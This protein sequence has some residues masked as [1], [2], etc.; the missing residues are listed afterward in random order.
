MEPL[1]TLARRYNLNVIE[2]AAQAHGT[3]YKGQRAGALGDAAGFSFY[4]SKNLGAFGDAGAVTTNDD[5]L[6]EQVRLLRNYG[7]RVKYENEIAG[8]NSRLDPI[9]AALLRVK[10]AHLD[11]W[12]ER[13]RLL[14]A[15]Y[16]D[17]LADVPDLVL[18]EVLDQ[19][20]PVWHVFVVQHPRRDELQQT[21]KQAGIGTLIHYPI[22]P[23]RSGAYASAIWAEG[24][25]PITERLAAQVL[26]L[27]MGPHLSTADQDAVIA[28]VRAFCAALK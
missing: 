8:Y 9:Q 7:S 21:L 3:C 19:T 26:S 12:N 28:A 18:P 17:A 16:L 5:A 14:A 2:D 25:F 22:P 10:L 13:R 27:P 20:N 6:A 15:R 4:P 24:T 1:L 11:A 23:H